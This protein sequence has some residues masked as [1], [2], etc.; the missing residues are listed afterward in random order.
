[1]ESI[2][3]PS[4]GFEEHPFGWILGYFVLKSDD[5][6]IRCGCGLRDTQYLCLDFGIFEPPLCDDA[7]F[8]NVALGRVSG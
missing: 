4:T 6:M 1:M 2:L 8:V 3:P 5:F 7:H